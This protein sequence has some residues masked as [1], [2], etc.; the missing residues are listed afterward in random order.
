MINKKKVDV[1]L[2]EIVDKASR[3]QLE[4]INKDRKDVDWKRIWA[5][6]TDVKDHADML[7]SEIENNK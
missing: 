1:W 7:K 5:Y 3:A 6:L 4:T 2:Q